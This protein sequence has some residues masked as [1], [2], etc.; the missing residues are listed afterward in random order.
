MP[1][2]K[3]NVFETLKFAEEVLRLLSRLQYKSAEEIQ[4][5]LQAVGIERNIRTVQRML[6]TLSEEYPQYVDCKRDTKPYSYRIKPHTNPLTISTMGEPEALVLRMADRWFNNLLPAQMK[7]AVKDYFKEADLLLGGRDKSSNALDWI[8][9]VAQ[10]SSTHRLVPSEVDQDIL[11][12]VTHCLYNNNILRSRYK[13]RL[14]KVSNPSIGPLGLF[15]RGPT[16]YLVGIE[17]DD[18][19]EVISD[20]KAYAM[21]RFLSA[22]GSNQTFDRPEDFVLSKFLEDEG[23]MFSSG[24]Y[25]R[26]TFETT[27]PAGYHLTESKAS[28]DQVFKETEMGYM[29][30]ATLPDSLETKNWLKSFGSELRLHRLEPVEQTDTRS[31]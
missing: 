28:E 9:K 21:H 8:E 2:P 27:E 3:Q 10:V 20:R 14:G 19:K 22:S 17:L 25:L 15:E 24:H 12:E 31:R 23:Y 18:N 16:L 7:K 6:T 11:D 4:S 29:F 26:V 5:S 13:N 1:K 30:T